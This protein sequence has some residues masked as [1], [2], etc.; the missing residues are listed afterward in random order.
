MQAVILAAGI[1]SRLG[2]YTQNNTK[3]MLSINGKTFIERDLDALENVGIRKCIIVVGYQKDNLM[4]FI[5]NKYKNIE[6]L[7]VV[8]NIYEKTNNIYSLFLAKEYLLQDDT[9]LLEIDLIFETRII[10]DLLDNPE[11]TLAVVAQYESWM[12]GTV[13]QI[14]KDAIITN[15]IPR[16]YFNYDEK[17]TYYK[18]VNIYKFSR[19]FLRISYIPFLEAYSQAMGN[20]EYYEQVLRVITTLEKNELK[21]LVLSD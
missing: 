4:R 15:F 12:D 5:G 6:M 16:K 14:S 20:N 3:C 11:P 13:V 8:N 1:G 18:T 19:D 10:Q 17:E 9:L 21:A 7:Y 2:K